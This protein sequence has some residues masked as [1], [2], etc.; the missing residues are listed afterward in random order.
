MSTG[1]KG[2][3]PRVEIRI[4]DSATGSY[5]T[6]ARTGDERTGVYATFF[7]DTK[8]VNFTKEN[9]PLSVTTDP[10]ITR[11]QSTS[12]SSN[13]VAYWTFDLKDQVSGFPNGFH[14]DVSGNDHGL[15]GTLAGSRTTSDVPPRLESQSSYDFDYGE[16]NPGTFD[17]FFVSGSSLVGD[18]SF[19]DGASDN[20]FSISV[21]VK[22][23]FTVEKGS[24]NLPDEPLLRQTIIAKSGSTGREWT[25]FFS[26]GGLNFGVHDE[27][28]GG[29]IVSTGRFSPEGKLHTFR[30]GDWNHIGATYDGAGTTNSF[31]MYVNGE[32]I[33]GVGAAAGA[34]TAMEA[35]GEAV[36]VGVNNLPVTTDAFDN[37]AIG[38]KLDDLAIFD[39][40]LT[41]DEFI[42]IASPQQGISF[43]TGLPINS[44][45]LAR[46]NLSSS[47][48]ASGT[49]LPGNIQ[50]F[51]GFTPGQNLSPFNEERHPEQSLE[52][53]FYLTGSI[54]K[55][56]TLGFQSRLSSK[57]KLSIILNNST[58]FN[59]RNTTASLSYL[60]VDG[61]GYRKVD[62]QN[63]TDSD[64]AGD[65]GVFSFGWDA[66]LFGPLGNNIQ[67]GSVVAG[68]PGTLSV[69][70]A[71]MSGSGIGFFGASVGGA[72][73]ESLRYVQD[74]SSCLNE[75]HSA[76][77]NE[78]I[79]MSSLIAHP[80]LLE[81]AIIDV[82]LSVSGQWF[83]ETTIVSYAVSGTE[84]VG[85]MG[86]PCV[87]V[88]LLRQEADDYRELILSSTIIPELDNVTT[89]FEHPDQLGFDGLDSVSGFA[90]F[91]T[92]GAV[93][94]GGAS[95]S[96]E[97]SVRLEITPT[98]TNG[99]M[100]ISPGDI[101]AF[102][103]SFIVNVNPFGRAMNVK[104]SGRS[105]FGK[106]FLISNLG[107][108]R[109][110]GVS[111]PLPQTTAIIFMYEKTVSSP[112]LLFPEDTLVF[113]IS[114]HR[115]VVGTL[116]N[117]SERFV[118]G[119]QNYGD[120]FFKLGSGDV[121][122]TLYGSL[123][124]DGKEFHDTLNQPLTSLAVHEAIHADNPVLDQ[125]DVERRESFIGS[126]ADQFV[127]GN[128]GD[129][130]RGR[131]GSIVNNTVGQFSASLLRGI[132]ISSNERYYD[133][134][135]PR[136]DQ[137]WS[138]DGVLI[139]N[140]DSILKIGAFVMG[141][142][143]HSSTGSF[144]ESIYNK[145]WF[146]S[147]PFEPKYGKVDRSIEPLN[148]VINEDNDIVSL[149]TLGRAVG[150]DATGAKIDVLVQN[151]LGVPITED[152]DRVI[153][154]GL[155]GIGSAL[156]GS[157]EFVNRL[158]GGLSLFGYYTNVKVRGWK[159][160]ILNA[161]ETNSSVVFRRDRFG[162]FRDMLEQRDFSKYYVVE[163]ENGNPVSPTVTTSP[164]VVKFADLDPEST[165]S[166]NL[167][168]E[169]TSSLPYFDADKDDGRNRGPL[170]D[171]EIIAP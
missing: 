40:V 8:T 89:V 117:E 147:F 106:E 168:N 90:P 158:D 137:V 44:V 113:A 101:P 59:I 141:A 136:P 171:V 142:V 24:G 145:D 81:K 77:S 132:N 112:Y 46:S 130:T 92:P 96:F 13:L 122:I 129:G 2:L 5:P 28:T 125:F 116:F 121:K 109:S 41:K 99:I 138:V 166:S 65:T 19:G 94:S 16:Q 159:Y 160:G 169:A 11:F 47:I 107:S 152:K 85:D 128:M 52:T 105:I 68:T 115:P 29:N 66:K 114:K 127:T 124:K 82:P 93:I 70:N 31:T 126:Y 30:I 170:P 134:L 131:K 91:A 149:Y 57:T 135:M 139:T 61:S 43:P 33:D 32:E 163:D 54:V 75:R 15:T 108:E 74:Q 7:D 20:P 22:R 18:F 76:N 1:F 146:K 165:F 155:Y 27:S 55:D 95:G 45:H 38:G 167:S 50:Q 64:H 110:L 104:P 83:D 97:G 23:I 39:R 71:V 56:T 84:F 140:F 35:T 73:R 25:L 118:T 36:T 21:W 6:I 143:N 4:R 86:G 88:S 42:R 79:K 63:T 144:P 58:D 37:D 153:L 87:T 80:F 151:N 72:L 48:I 111:D 119:A 3:P 62:P 120:S 148:N 78:L 157:A 10:P 156:S 150:N 49:V 60:S 69:P 51:V 14:N 53:N 162:Q 123:I 103:E 161:L 26:P 133:T 9:A 12:F 100:S 154:K 34:Y 98:L 67:S 164:I 17:E 102:A